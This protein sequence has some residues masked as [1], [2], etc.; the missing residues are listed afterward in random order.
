M[1]LLFKEAEFL[2]ALA[3]PACPIKLLL[4]NFSKQNIIGVLV[5]EIAVPAAP[6]AAQ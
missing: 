5:P 6:P 4:S 3:S 2:M 1:P